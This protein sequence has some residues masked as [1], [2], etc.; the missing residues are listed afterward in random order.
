MRFRVIVLSF[1][2]LV[3][4]VA[5]AQ[6]FGVMESAETID[7]GN[8]KLRVNPLLFFNNGVDDEEKGVAVTAGYGFTRSFDVEGGVAFYDG[9]RVF[10]GNAEFWLM[11]N[12]PFDFSVIPGLHVTRGD[13]AYDATGVDLTFLASKHATPRLDVYGA[14]DFAFENVTDDRVRDANYKT[15]HLVPGLEYKLHEDIDLLA[16]VGI[17]LNDSAAHYISG[18]VAFYFR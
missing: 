1:V 6:D 4:S 18:G 12:R 14:L 13:R 3:P 8:F 9:L 2:L 7:R 11:K 5:L 10:G 17:G 15:V 16:E